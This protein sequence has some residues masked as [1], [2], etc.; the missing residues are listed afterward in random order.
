M[1]CRIIG[2]SA[3]YERHMIV[4]GR[5]T[6]PCTLTDY[7]LEVTEQRRINVIHL[8]CH[9]VS[10]ATS[11]VICLFVFLQRCNE[12]IVMRPQRRREDGVQKS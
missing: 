10:K 7:C 1:K 12:D 4:E 3:S 6:F 5:L 9:I 8:I 11:L 2:T